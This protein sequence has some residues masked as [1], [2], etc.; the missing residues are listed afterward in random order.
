MKYQAVTATQQRTWDSQKQL[1]IAVS[2]RIWL[3][4]TNHL[5]V[6]GLV[7]RYLRV[8]N[9][10]VQLYP[11]VHLPVLHLL[12][13]STKLTGLTCP[14][15]L[16]SV[17]SLLTLNT[18]L[19]AAVLLLAL[20]NCLAWQSVCQ[21]CPGWSKAEEAAV[22]RL[23]PNL[24]A[25]TETG[26]SEQ[27]HSITKIFTMKVCWLAI[28]WDKTSSINKQRKLWVSLVRGLGLFGEFSMMQ[29]TSSEFKVCWLAVGWVKQCSLISSVNFVHC[30]RARQLC[31][32][33]GGHPGMPISNTVIVL[34]VSG[35]KAK[36][37][38]NI[39]CYVCSVQSS[40]LVCVWLLWI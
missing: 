19:P 37:N 10:K 16:L 33:R 3:L 28:G 36:L 7:L 23:L 17:L 24:H 6:L 5:L 8:I 20:P 11:H 40:P 32:S 18:L 26:A 27:T 4:P 31:E 15:N 13:C 34:M 1:W 39:H 30:Y 22:R 25:S 2:K 14:Q 35:R 21:V 9:R 29:V 12:S 38:F